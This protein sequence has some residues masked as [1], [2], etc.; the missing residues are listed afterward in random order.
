MAPQAATTEPTLR[1]AEPRL[2]GG[3]KWRWGKREILNERR[4]KYRYTCG[5]PD[6]TAAHVLNHCF[7][8]HSVAITNRHRAAV[9]RNVLLAMPQDVR[10]NTRVEQTVEGSGSLDKPDIVI[11]DKRQHTAHIV[12]ICCPYDKRYGALEAARIHKEMKYQHLVDYFSGCGLTASASALVV[13]SLGSWDPKNHQMI[14]ILGTPTLS[15]GN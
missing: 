2:Q 1:N 13:G 6:E 4:N 5:Y 3:K 15:S 12:D 7:V 9:L 11:I 8:R 10:N 14:K